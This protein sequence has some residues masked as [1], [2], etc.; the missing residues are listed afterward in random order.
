MKIIIATGAS[1]GHLYPAL[2]LAEEL[3]DSNEI[4]FVC[5]RGKI[6][7]QIRR[8]GFR[9]I[10]ISIVKFRGLRNI[11]YFL[12]RLVQSGGESI[13]IINE[14]RPQ[15]VIGFGSFVSLP[16][17]CVA[18]LRNIPTI[19]HEQ[20][21]VPGLANR[22]LS[23]FA[24]RIAVSF[25]QTSKYFPQKQVFLTG[26]PV[27]KELSGVDRAAARQRFGLAE[28]KFTI[29][30]LGGSQGSHH[31]NVKFIQAIAQVEDKGEFQIIHL[32]GETDYLW[33]AA[34]YKKRGLSHRVFVFL[35][36]MGY[37][38]RLTNL[39]ISRAGASA[40]TE[41]SLF[42]IPAI[43]IPYPFAR[44][45]Q[46]PNALGLAEKGGAVLIRDKDLTADTLRDE[47][48]RLMNNPQLLQEM[49]QKSKTLAIPFAARNLASTIKEMVN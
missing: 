13:R 4:I 31:I 15:A 23:K 22:I 28:E 12:V 16:V 26:C 43:L 30:V 5:D 49:A 29:L 46:L 20:N 32:T 37:A 38:Y 34:E 18:R 45:H 19:I 9:V 25:A 39:V 10:P 1:G 11:F 41:I 2:S 47:I 40:V 6:E 35:E 36:E 33:V 44:S 3:V 7:E 42:G 27:R 17:V 24:K 14:I 48:L 8:K 21:V